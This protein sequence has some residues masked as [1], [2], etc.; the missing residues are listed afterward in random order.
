MSQFYM[1]GHF[2]FNFFFQIR[3]Y[4]LIVKVFEENI[5]NMIV[6]VLGR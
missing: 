3:V 5:G 4:Y 1:Y 6:R 2:L